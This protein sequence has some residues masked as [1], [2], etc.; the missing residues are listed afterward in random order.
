M[1]ETT[2]T[3][4]F[5]S[6]FIQIFGIILLFVQNF[7]IFVYYNIRK[8]SKK[9]GTCSKNIL[10]MKEGFMDVQKYSN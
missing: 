7:Y 10:G 2:G 6:F 8:Y 9:S 1:P 3:T 4:G 5:F